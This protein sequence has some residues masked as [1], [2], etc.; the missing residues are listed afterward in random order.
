MPPEWREI[1][2][3]LKDKYSQEAE[4]Y[5]HMF[6]SPIKTRA[7]G[8]SKLSMDYS[9]YIQETVNTLVLKKLHRIYPTNQLGA[10][11]RRES[12]KYMK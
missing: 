2:N 10:D 1:S 5:V 9:S 3:E 11:T 4:N 6:V 7:A 8:I 12:L